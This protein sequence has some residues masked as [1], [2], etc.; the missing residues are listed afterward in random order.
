MRTFILRPLTLL[1]VSLLLFGP[2]AYMTGLH[3]VLAG[4]ELRGYALLMGV[5]AVM[6]LAAAIVRRLPLLGR[7]SHAAFVLDEV[8]SFFVGSVHMV[9]F[10]LAF[11]MWVN[12]KALAQVQ[13]IT[14][15]S[16]QTH[17]RN[18]AA[19]AGFYLALVV[20]ARL[21]EIARRKTC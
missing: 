1:V 21:T 4:F 19:L 11:N 15:M 6:S 9:T 14:A 12:Y 2:I 13:E 3:S 16:V 5:Y 20:L 10:L 8:S 7:N 18:A 17:A